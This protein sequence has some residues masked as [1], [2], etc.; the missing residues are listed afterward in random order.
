MLYQKI[1]VATDL[2]ENGNRAFAVAEQYRQ[3]SGGVITPA[4]ALT[5]PV[6]PE[7]IRLPSLDDAAT[8][9][10]MEFSYRKCREAAEKFTPS[11]F[12]DQPYISYG[13][14][15]RVLVSASAGYDLMVMSTHGR[16]GFRKFIMGSVA[17]KVCRMSKIPVLVTSPGDTPGPFNNILLTTDFSDESCKAFEKAHWMLQQTDASF[18]LL[19]VLSIEY[20]GGLA[21]KEQLYDTVNERLKRFRDEHFAGFEERV[22]TH[23]VVSGNSVHRAISKH[24]E[25]QAYDLIIISTAGRTGIDYVVLGSTAAHVIQTAPVPVLT[26]RP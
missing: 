3:I 23:L 14:P 21:D 25:G 15:A 7:G 19:H 1:L 22:K 12:V 16:T 11:D 5:E 10:L 9:Q 13:D 26:V 2:S 20:A 4:H 18:T 6:W 24:I 17:S 8:K